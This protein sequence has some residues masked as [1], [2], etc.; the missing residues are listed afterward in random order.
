MRVYFMRRK[1][2]GLDSIDSY[3]S[4]WIGGTGGKPTGKGTSDG[5]KITRLGGSG[6]S[7]I[8][9]VGRADEDLI[10]NL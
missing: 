5:D 7:I 3:E 6:K 1:G 2:D 9:M 8:G 10:R 4:R